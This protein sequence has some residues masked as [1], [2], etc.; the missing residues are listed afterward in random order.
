M[1]AIKGITH[2]N[3]GTGMGVGFFLREEKTESS[4]EQNENPLH[5]LQYQPAMILSVEN[6]KL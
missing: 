4:V 5:P 6:A 3:W 1:L 2:A